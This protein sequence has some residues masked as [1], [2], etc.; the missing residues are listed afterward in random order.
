MK[1][2]MRALGVATFVSQ[3]GS[4]TAAGTAA[5]PPR[6]FGGHRNSWLAPILAAFH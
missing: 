1:S 4:K 6:R 2:H 5:G 3:E